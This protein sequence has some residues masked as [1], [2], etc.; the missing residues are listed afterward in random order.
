MWV[1]FWLIGAESCSAGAQAKTVGFSLLISYSLV[2][3]RWWV[4]AL[5]TVSGERLK[6]DYSYMYRLGDRFT[7]KG[8]TVSPGKGD[9]FTGLGVTV[10][11]VKT[12]GLMSFIHSPTQGRGVACR[13]D[14][15]TGC[16]VGLKM[17]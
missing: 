12:F 5:S 6:K 14:R 8:V 9:C 11:P 2:V 16:R 15:F 3:V 4:G 13:G 17:G 10:S 1:P 7:G